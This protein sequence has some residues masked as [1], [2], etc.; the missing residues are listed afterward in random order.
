MPAL[1]TDAGLA[2]MAPDTEKVVITPTAE[3][4]KPWMMNWASS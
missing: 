1:L 4:T 3:R 2:I